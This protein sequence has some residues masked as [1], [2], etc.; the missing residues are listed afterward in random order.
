VAGSGRGLESVAVDLVQ[1]AA[2]VAGPAVEG[3]LGIG[4]GS[5]TTGSGVQAHLGQV[6]EELDLRLVGLFLR[7]GQGRRPAFG[8]NERMQTDPHWREQILFFEYFNGDT[9]E[10]LGASHQ[11]GW[12]ALV[13]NLIA[14]RSRCPASAA[15]SS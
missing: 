9:G 5:S 13:G 1:P 10:G 8:S 14:N 15:D 7:D 12:T 3:L 2:Q 11:T 6:A 4:P